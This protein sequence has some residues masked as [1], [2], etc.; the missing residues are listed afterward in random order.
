[1][2]KTRAY[3]TH[4]IRTTKSPWDNLQ[5]TLELQENLFRT[6]TDMTRLS[7][8]PARNMRRVPAPSLAGLRIE[9]HA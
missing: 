4:S 5:K 9:R 7:L 1:M 6:S 8:D 3:S 2:M